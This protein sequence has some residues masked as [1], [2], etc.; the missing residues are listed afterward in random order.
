MP[1]SLR[2]AIGWFIVL[3][4][5]F[6]PF[7]IA[8]GIYNK[9]IYI[10][11][12]ELFAIYQ[13]YMPLSSAYTSSIGAYT[14]FMHEDEIEA[15]TGGHYRLFF[16]K[17][18]SE[19]AE[20]ARRFVPIFGIPSLITWG[21]GFVS[22]IAFFVA[23]LVRS[24]KV[25]RLDNKYF[26][27]ALIFLVGFIIPIVIMSYQSSKDT[28][29]KSNLI[30]DIGGYSTNIINK[31]IEI[32]NLFYETAMIEQSD[33]WNYDNWLSQMF[34]V[35]KKNESFFK[36]LQ[37]IKKWI[38]PKGSHFP[39]YEDIILPAIDMCNRLNKYFELATYIS[40]NIDEKRM[41]KA[42]GYAEFSEI[43]EKLADSLNGAIRYSSIYMKD[44]LNYD[45]SNKDALAKFKSM[46]N[47]PP[48]T[49]YNVKL[50]FGYMVYQE[51]KK[52]ADMEE[53]YEK[54]VELLKNKQ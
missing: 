37:S 3:V 31:F 48:D 52:K 44:I 39:K 41:S 20:K 6:I 5:F 16:A 10:L 42:E 18:F 47:D 33:T 7:L 35:K 4:I 19:N 2:Y 26:L 9:W 27:T 40:S 15:E 43:L 11:E 30:Y 23:G 17:G 13:D 12:D 45:F 32:T 21:I 54:R 46:D 8:S 29:R 14:F 53:A 50:L 24:I 49:K 25:R 22:L 51:I 36:E 38:A 1:K 28:M 34:L